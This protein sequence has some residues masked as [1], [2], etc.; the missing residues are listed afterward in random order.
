MPNFAARSMIDRIFQVP[1]PR[2]VRRG[3]KEIDGRELA[4]QSI[5]IADADQSLIKGVPPFFDG[6]G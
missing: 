4:G 1:S 6:N 3:P 2:A 5:H